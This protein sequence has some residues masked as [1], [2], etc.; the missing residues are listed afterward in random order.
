MMALDEGRDRGL[1][2]RKDT[3]DE[4]EIAGRRRRRIRG[5]GSLLAGRRATRVLA[6]KITPMDHREGM[7]ANLVT[8]ALV[9]AGALAWLATFPAAA[10]LGAFMVW[11]LP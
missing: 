9:A 3:P 1:V 4:I 8:S 2:P 7:T 5:A 6:E 10:C 11:V